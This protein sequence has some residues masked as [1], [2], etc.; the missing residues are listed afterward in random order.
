MNAK[1]PGPQ[2]PPAAAMA[3]PSMPPKPEAPQA[4]APPI[5]Y[6]DHI[7]PIIN[8]KCAGCHNPDKSRGGLV[9]VTY[10]D[11]M[12]GGSSGKVVEPGS[13]DGSRLYLLVSHKEEPYMPPKA[14]KLDEARLTTIRKWIEGGAL[15]DAKAKPMAM[16]PKEP[17]KPQATA[18]SEQDGPMP[19]H[20]PA[21][22][23]RKPVHPPPAVALAA[24]P[25]ADLL[26]VG[27]NGQIAFYQLSTRQLLG[28]L[29]FP[30]GRIEELVFS[31]DG[32][33]LLA[34]G[35]Q[36]GKSGTA[37]VFDV[38]TGARKGAFDRHYDAVLAAAV[39]PDTGLV[40]VGGTNAKVRVFNSYGGSKVYELTAH[41]DWISALEFSPDGT[42]LAS[43]DRAGGLFV[44]EADTGRE[45]HNLRGH[46][47][48]VKGL[49]F[50]A[51]SQM[52]ASAGADGS[53]RLWDM[54]EGRQRK[55]WGAHDGAALSVRFSPDGRLVTSGAD[56]Q[57]RIW[58]QD[59]KNLRDLPRQDDWVYRATFSADAKAVVA[60]T[61]R[62]AVAFFETDS[63]KP[64]ATLSTVPGGS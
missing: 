49:C 54:D 46:T 39:S 37:V 36:T 9:L 56:G 32:T 21:V 18:R 16:K 23:I 3:A 45:V 61:Y 28:V 64:I 13:P 6:A 41:N 38:E 57:V 63:G 62:G 26:A 7:L 12:Q 47:G 11:L 44:W 51:D 52:L 10:N 5:N 25:N 42:L 35:G 19:A 22:E 27:G 4:G 34:A 20:L 53:V 48:A 59:G 8:D 17:P 14:D 50:R 60:G 58:N 29:D 33:W 30:E 43:A 2:P 15:P 31:G 24:S 40:A 1:P 55:Q